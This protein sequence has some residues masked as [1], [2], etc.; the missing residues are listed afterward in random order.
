MHQCTPRHCGNARGVLC[1]TWSRCVPPSVRIR[2]CV[3]ILVSGCLV[4]TLVPSRLIP[5]CLVAS[6]ACVWSP[7]TLVSGRLLPL[8]LVASY[9]CVWSPCTLV[10]GRL[11]P[12][13][14]VA[15]YPCVWSPR[16]LVSG[17]LASYSCALSPPRTLVSGRRLL[18]LWLVDV[19]SSLLMCSCSA[20]SEARLGRSS[21]KTR[22]SLVVARCRGPALRPGPEARLCGR[23]R[24]SIRRVGLHK[25]LT[26]KQQ[27]YPKRQLYAAGVGLRARR[28]PARR[29]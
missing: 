10:S 6:Y 26:S 15:L 28:R 13:C 24:T 17:R 7:L 27:L 11:V 16:T 8:C 2:L 19:G 29:V 25:W 22:G 18:P 21:H 23:C 5:L 20:D 12:L 4:C 3:C 14:L 9:P 1:Y